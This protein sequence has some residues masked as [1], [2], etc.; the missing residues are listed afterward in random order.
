[1]RA[2]SGEPQALGCTAWRWVTLDELDAYPFPVTDR[3]IIAVLRQLSSNSV[4]N[5]KQNPTVISV[6]KIIFSLHRNIFASSLV[7]LEIIAS[8]M[9]AQCGWQRVAP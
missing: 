3:K 4:P 7:T 1:M 6:G 8:P 2:I 5:S 9:H